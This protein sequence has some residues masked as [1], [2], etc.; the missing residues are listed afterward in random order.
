LQDGVE[1]REQLL[2][3]QKPAEGPADGSCWVAYKGPF[4]QVSDEAG[5]SYPCGQRVRVSARSAAILRQ[6]PM[7]DQFTFFTSQAGPG[8][9]AAH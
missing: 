8:C 7:K 2:Q 1:M 4:A 5:N 6:G 3:A 9:S